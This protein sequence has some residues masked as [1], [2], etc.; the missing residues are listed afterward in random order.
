VWE[1]IKDRCL[2]TRD[3]AYPD[4]GGRGIDICDEWRNSFVAF[5]TWAYENRYVE[6]KLPSGRNRL[7]IDR[8][9]ND[10]GYHPSNCRWAT[11][12]EQNNNR[13]SNH[14]VTINGVTKT[15]AEW[16]EY[17]HLKPSTLKQR[18][19]RGWK[20]EDLLLPANE[21]RNNGNS[22]YT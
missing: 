3:R 11:A 2:N 10:K 15:L 16:T 8:I 9:D 7:M 21:R 14:R 17:A 13:R 12:K 22:V 4:Y 5:A 1:G 6:E 18:L 19:Y 20:L